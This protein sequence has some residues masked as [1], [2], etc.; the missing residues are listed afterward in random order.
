M[1]STLRFKQTQVPRQQGEIARL[2]VAQGPDQGAVYVVFGPKVTLGR[3]EEN[4]AVILDLKTS[5]L[6]AELAVVSGAWRIK[7]LGSVNGILFQ[8]KAL[9][10]TPVTWGDV[11][12]LGET[13]LELTHVDLMERVQTQSRVSRQPFPFFRRREGPSGSPGPKVIVGVV[14]LGVLFFL[15]P[16]EDDSKKVKKKKKATNDK[17]E[18]APFLPKADYNKATE[19]L[20]KDGLREYFVGNYSRAKTQFE[21]VLQIAPA[22][23]LAKIYLENCNQAVESTISANLEQGKKALDAGKLREAKAHFSR[24][25]RLLFKDQTNP[26]YIEAKEQFDKV[27]KLLSGEANAA[28]AGS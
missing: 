4:D 18:L 27:Q 7:D 13:A 25:M 8:G 24:V 5:R 22:H 10:E 12:I 21:T 3:G 19:T 14:V 2:R 23:Q 26:Q 11:F 15:L 1:G 16:G 17:V 28:G 20:F 6:H 9:R